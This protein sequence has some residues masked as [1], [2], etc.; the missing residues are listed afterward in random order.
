ML[1]L[2]PRSGPILMLPQ[3]E[4]VVVLF[5]KQ[6]PPAAGEKRTRM[7]IQARYYRN[8]KRIPVMD[9][10]GLAAFD[11]DGRRREESCKV[12]E[13]TQKKGRRIGLLDSFP[14]RA[15]LYSW[16]DEA[17]R[18]LVEPRGRVV[19]RQIETSAARSLRKRAARRRS[20]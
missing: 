10:S 15:M 18:R 4:D 8:N 2:L 11:A 12:R 1:A 17:H 5:N 19:M 14:E 6:F 9:Q 3:W 20:A 7:G 16:V 13:Q